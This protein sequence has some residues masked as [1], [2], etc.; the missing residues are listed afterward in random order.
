MCEPSVGRSTPRHLLTTFLGC[1]A[2]SFPEVHQSAVLPFLAERRDSKCCWSFWSWEAAG[3]I[4]SLH[5]TSEGN[6]VFGS[7]CCF[8]FCRLKSTLMWWQWPYQESL[9]LGGSWGPPGREDSWPSALQLLME[10]A[11]VGIFSPHHIF[12]YF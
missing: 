4:Y 3:D 6:T 1:M 2:R 5:I 10:E 7:W 12:L 8:L 11:F 9:W